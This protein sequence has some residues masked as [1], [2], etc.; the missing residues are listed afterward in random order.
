[1]YCFICIVL[2]LA[3]VAYVW[4]IKRI[5]STKVHRAYK[6]VFPLGTGF[7]DGITLE[8]RNGEVR[9]FILRGGWLEYPNMINVEFDLEDKNLNK[10]LHFYRNFIIQHKHQ[11]PDK[12]TLPVK[13]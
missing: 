4:Y 12:T 7:A 13:V 10:D 1:M 9:H 8:Y 6:E 3:T 2:G 11:Y 5:T